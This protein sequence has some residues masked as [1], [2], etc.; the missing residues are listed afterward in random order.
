MLWTEVEVCLPTRT[1]F[2]CMYSRVAQPDIGNPVAA[3]L[4]DDL[5]RTAS[6]VI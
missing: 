2:G 3:A 4:R 6:D 5:P 1:S